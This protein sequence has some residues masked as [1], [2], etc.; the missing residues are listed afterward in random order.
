MIYVLIGISLPSFWIGLVLSYLVGYK[1]G[2]TPIAGYCEV[3]SVPEA[4][5]RWDGLRTT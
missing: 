2:W 1:L 5:L 4:A 3:F